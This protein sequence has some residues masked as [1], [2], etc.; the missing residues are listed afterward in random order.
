MMMLQSVAK[1]KQPIIFTIMV[2]LFFT[3]MSRIDFIVHNTLYNYGLVFS[4]E[5]ANSYWLTY[6]ALFIAF[7]IVVSITYWLASNKTRKDLKLSCALL[8]TITLLAI[9]GLQDILFF[10]LWGGGLPPISVVWWW[11]PWVS[12]MGTWN[13]QMQIALTTLMLCTSMFT[14]IIAAKNPQPIHRGY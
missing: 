2:F 1:F 9:G 14:W 6:N 11:V 13:S 4:Y 12:V 10:V 3:L 8:G 5:W 7:G